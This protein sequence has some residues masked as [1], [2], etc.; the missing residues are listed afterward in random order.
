MK[1]GIHPAY[2]QV[3][4]FDV[5]SGFKMLT[6]STKSSNEKMEWE[7]GNSY[8]VIRVD[9]SSASHPFYTGKQ[10]NTDKGGRVD[11]FNQRIQ[12]KK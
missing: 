7:D 1:Q 12:Q 9:T 6:G 4:F 3:L 8:P 5:S 11:R 2:H 10:R